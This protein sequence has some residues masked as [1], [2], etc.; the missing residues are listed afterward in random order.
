MKI[1]ADEN[2]PF[3]KEAF[4]CFGNLKL[5]PGRNISNAELKDAEILIVRSITTVDK[6]LLQGTRIKFVGTATIG[7]DHIDLDYLNESGITYANAAGCNADS[8]NEYVWAAIFKSVVEKKI[9]LEGK[10]IGVVGVGNIGSRVVCTAEKLGLKVLQNDPPLKR[11]TNNK[12]F[13]DLNEALSADIITFHVPLTYEGEDKTFHLLNEKNLQQ[14]KPGAIIINSSR[15]PVIDN[16]ALLNC[17]KNDSDMVTILDVWEIE[18]NINVELLE[19]TFIGT[20]HIAGYSYEGKVNGTL[21]I[22]NELCK[23]LEVKPGWTPQL[24]MIENP[25][26]EFNFD[27]GFEKSI[28][29]VIKQAYNIDEDN[30]AL[31]KLLTDKSLTSAIYFDKL[32]KEYRQRREF[33]NYSIEMSAKDLNIKKALASLRFNLT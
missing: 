4:G 31:K 24:P 1:I 7:F 20:A 6:N 23:F 19:K 28:D 5:L 32:R 10:T 11:R 17:M 16:T 15:G 33:T 3:A 29:N 14:I 18:P 9:P 26:I 12:N 21:M 27:I 25:T 8:V 22:Y 2:I 30:I 13:V